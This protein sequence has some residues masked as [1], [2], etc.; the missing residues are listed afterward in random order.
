M[1]AFYTIT[2]ANLDELITLK[3]YKNIFIKTT[4]EL[5]TIKN[6]QIFYPP[7]YFINKTR[8]YKLFPSLQTKQNDFIPYQWQ[9]DFVNF[10]LT[11]LSQA[12]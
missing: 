7:H 8:Q 9:Q 4:Y 5:Y 12:R 11:N 10:I 2:K 3:K 6:K 1:R